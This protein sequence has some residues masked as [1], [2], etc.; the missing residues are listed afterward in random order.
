MISKKL[1][2]VFAIGYCSSALWV[3]EYS[4]KLKKDGE[5]RRREMAEDFPEMTIYLL[6]LANYSS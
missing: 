6:I 3:V 5:Q 4:W 1:E 2:S